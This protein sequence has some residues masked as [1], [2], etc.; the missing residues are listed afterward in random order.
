[1]ILLWMIRCQGKKIAQRLDLPGTGFVLVTHARLVSAFAAS[2]NEV[3]DRRL[4]F[5]AG[6]STLVTPYR[7]RPLLT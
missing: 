3:A 4:W 1:M 2:A 5:D 7:T 6:R